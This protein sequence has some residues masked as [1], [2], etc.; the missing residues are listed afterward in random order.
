MSQPGIVFPLFTTCN[1]VFY[2]L[3]ISTLLDVWNCHCL[4]SSLYEKQC[5]G[6]G[7]VWVRGLTAAIPLPH[8]QWWHQQGVNHADCWNPAVCAGLSIGLIRCL[9]KP[10]LQA[11]RSLSLHALQCIISFGCRSNVSF[12]TFWVIYEYDSSDTSLHNSAFCAV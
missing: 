8:G 2:F 4:R 3:G 1:L 6:K 9:V 12:Y 7:K 11:W 10:P 5:Y